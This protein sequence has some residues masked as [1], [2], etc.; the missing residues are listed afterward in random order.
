MHNNLFFLQ[1]SES[2]E[3]KPCSRTKMNLSLRIS[4]LNK[5]KKE[6]TKSFSMQNTSSVTPVPNC[7]FAANDV[8]Q[9]EKKTSNDVMFLRGQTRFALISSKFVSRKRF[10]GDCF[11]VTH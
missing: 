10:V 2:F 7:F 4:L 8:M 5:L 6:A 3:F 1:A 9:R 11:D